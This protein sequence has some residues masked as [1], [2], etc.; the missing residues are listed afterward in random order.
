MFV[1]FC[2]LKFF[3][4]PIFRPSNK[5]YQLQQLV[6]WYNQVEAVHL[7]LQQRPDRQRLGEL[8]DQVGYCGS[9]YLF[10]YR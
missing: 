3:K 1:F 4:T 7:R 2:F 5:R 9:P 6:P 10:G 8:Y